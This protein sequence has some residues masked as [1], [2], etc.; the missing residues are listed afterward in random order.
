VLDKVK[1]ANEI[2]AF[3][4]MGD[5][6]ATRLGLNSQLKKFM[7]EATTEIRDMHAASKPIP[8]SRITPLCL[9]TLKSFN[10][11]FGMT[12]RRSLGA[13]P[14]Y[15]SACNCNIDGESIQLA[16][17]RLLAR[18]ETRKVMI[19]FSDGQPSCDV[20]DRALSTHLKDVVPKIE[21]SGVEVLGLGLM[22]NAVRSYYQK[23]DVVNNA[24][25][26][27]QKI[28]SILRK[29]VLGI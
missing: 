5:N 9:Y 13:L 26:I 2:V 29:L 6:T 23:S 4:T 18:K 11:R 14:H 7:D 3:S 8:F 28:L 22:N 10:A 27:P 20:N 17:Q 12:E 15:D 1:V 16:A 21:A 24:A 19:V 25:E